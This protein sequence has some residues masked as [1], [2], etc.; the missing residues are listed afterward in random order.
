MGGSLRYPTSNTLASRD[1]RTLYT[2][3]QAGRIYS[4][5]QA[6]RYAVTLTA[7]FYFKHQALGGPHAL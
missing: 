7:P 2:T 1:G 3:F 5:Q 6:P 4:F